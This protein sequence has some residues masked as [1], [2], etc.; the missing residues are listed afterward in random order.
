MLRFRSASIAHLT[1]CSFN[2]IVHLPGDYSF[3]NPALRL[4]LEQNPL[5]PVVAMNY[6]RGT[7]ILLDSLAASV[8]AYPEHCVAYGDALG[9][10]RSGVGESFKI[11]AF[12]KRKKEIKSGKDSFECK[13]VGNFFFSP[14]LCSSLPPFL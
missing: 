3:L 13:M 11:K 2:Q 5:D 8:L 10:G 1:L 4:E 9:S 12:D 14:S 6:K 7:P